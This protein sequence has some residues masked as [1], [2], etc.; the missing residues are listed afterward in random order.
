M[1]RH[2]CK[3]SILLNCLTVV[4]VFP[5]YKLLISLCYF[6]PATCLI[7]VLISFLFFWYILIR[8]FSYCL[9]YVFK[10]FFYCFSIVFFAFL[11]FFTFIFMFILCPFCCRFYFFVVGFSTRFVVG[12]LHVFKHNFNEKLSCYSDLYT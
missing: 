9:I 5:L 11:L 1:I 7:V 12:F 8:W 6:N 10:L 2:V 3:A 4:F